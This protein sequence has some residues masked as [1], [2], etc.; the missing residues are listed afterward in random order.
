MEEIYLHKLSLRDI[1]PTAMRLLILRTMMEMKRA[2]SVTDL[3]DK[4]DTVDKSTIFR[5]L[6]LFLSHHLIHGVD[7]GS[8]SLK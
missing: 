6:T 3:E 1:K 5:T 2:V 4:L 8:G 7:D